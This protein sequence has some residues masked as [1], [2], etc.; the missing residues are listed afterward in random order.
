MLEWMHDAE[1]Q[2]GFRKNMLGATLEDALGFIEGALKEELRTGSS[3][4]YAIVGEEDEYLGTISLKNLD[5]E[6]QTAEYAITTR[7][8]AHG[9]GAAFH[10]TGLLL[11]KA[12]YE[13]GLHRVYLSVYADN[14]RA[15]R[16]YEKCGFQLEG[17]FREHFLVDGKRQNWKWYGILKE[18]FSED[19]FH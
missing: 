2:K 12:F 16:L 5:L 3:L 15:I 13:L 6:N 19:L 7:E 4:H 18:E 11:H 14:E 1:I 10:A 9:T 17:E 8:K